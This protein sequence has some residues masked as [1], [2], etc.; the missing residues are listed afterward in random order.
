M[1]NLLDITLCDTLGIIAIGLCIGLI[2]ANY[3]GKQAL[4]VGLVGAV[5]G[6][7]LVKVCNG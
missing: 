3:Y 7:R 4:I 6:N 1:K 2:G 5:A